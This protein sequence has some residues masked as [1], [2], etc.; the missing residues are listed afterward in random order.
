MFA[1]GN[2]GAIPLLY[3]SQPGEYQAPPLCKA[4]DVRTDVPAYCKIVKGNIECQLEDLL[5]IL[6]IIV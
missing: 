4:S 2:Q 6:I 5:G 3:K 1:K